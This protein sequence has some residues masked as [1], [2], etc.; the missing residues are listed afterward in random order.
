MLGCCQY[1]LRDSIVRDDGQAMDTL[2]DPKLLQLF[3]EEPGR[4][5]TSYASSSSPS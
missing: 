2:P 1:H 4:V 5:V 3:L